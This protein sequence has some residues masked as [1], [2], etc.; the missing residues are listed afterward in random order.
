MFRREYNQCYSSSI[1]NLRKVGSIQAIS[2]GHV[3]LSES[4]M[5]EE[6]MDHFIKTPFNSEDDY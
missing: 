4:G 5:E 3:R 2:S 6:T 1:G